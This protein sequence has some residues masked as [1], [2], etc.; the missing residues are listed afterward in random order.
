MT[1]IK[2]FTASVVFLLLFS[3]LNLGAQEK[4][5]RIREMERL[6]GHALELA[7]NGN[8]DESER[9]M[10]TVN[11]MRRAHHERS[12]NANGRVR[13]RNEA[14]EAI[15]DFRREMAY[16]RS[17]L[18][19]GVSEEESGEIRENLERLERAIDEKM[20]FLNEKVNNRDDRDRE[21]RDRRHES[22]EREHH[23]Q[24]EAWESRLHHLRAAAEHLHGAGLHEVAEQIEG[25]IRNL[26]NERHDHDGDGSSG[27]E[28]LIHKLMERMD[29]LNRQ[30]DGLRQ[31]VSRLRR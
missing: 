20:I 24:D 17:L 12:S 30:V 23:P 14:K 2:L 9:V 5:D 1:K 25:Q 7:K 16:L 3:A 15:A 28:P 11:E 4:D 6:Y 26:E 22:D 21:D 31:E 27:L 13:D 19:R 18:D 10:D 29:D 8:A